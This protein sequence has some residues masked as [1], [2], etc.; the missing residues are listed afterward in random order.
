LFGCELA[1]SEA[2]SNT[3]LRREQLTTY[4]RDD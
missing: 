3:K 1:R 4:S 2:N